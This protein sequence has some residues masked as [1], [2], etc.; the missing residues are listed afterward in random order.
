MEHQDFKLTVYKLKTCSIWLARGKVRSK[1]M[2]FLMFI[3]GTYYVR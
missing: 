1:N 3:I 2:G